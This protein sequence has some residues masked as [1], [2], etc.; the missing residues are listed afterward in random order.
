MRFTVLLL[1]SSLYTLSFGQKV[2]QY[3]NPFIGTSNY[4][5]THP[6]ANFPHGMASVTPF[7]VAHKKGE[8]NKFEKDS[9]WHSRPYVHENKFLTGFSHVNLSGVGCPDLGS[10]L[11]MPT[12][13]QLEFDSEKY[14]STYEN[15]VASPGYYS[16]ELIKYGVRT[17]MTSTLRTGLSKY[18]FPAG[19]SHIL[20]NLGLGL[21][22]ETGSYLRIV[23]P[24]EVEGFKNFGTFCYSDEDVRPV[25]FVMKLSKAP[26][27]FGAWKKMPP[28]Q[29]VEGE[30]IGYND[31]Y[32][33][34][35][36]YMFPLAGDDIG[37]YFTFTTS[38]DEQISVKVGIS[39]VS[40]EN[41]RENLES[42]QPK[43]EFENTHLANESKWDELL[44]RIVVESG[45]ENAKTIFYTA[46]YHNLIHPN[47]VN[48]VN[49]EYPKMSSHEIGKTETNRYTVFSIWDTYRNVHPLLSLV[50]PEIQSEMINTMLGMYEESGWLPK[51]ELIAMETD[52]MVGDP[53]TPVIT[54]TYLRGIRDF[55]IKKA[56]E[57]IKKA[58][59]TKESENRLRPGIDEYNK[60]GFVPVDTADIWGGS[61]ST[62]LEYY[63]ADWNIAQ[64]AKVLGY[65]EEARRY[66][67][68]SMGYKQLFDKSTGMLR[69]KFADGRWIPN[70]DPEAGKNFEAVVGYVE[71]NAWQYRFYVPHDIAGLTKLLGGKKKFYEQ[72]HLLF[73]TDNYDMANEP[74]I[75][76]PYLF[77]YIPGRERETQFQVNR[78]INKYYKNSPDGIP[79]NDDTGSLSAW[80]AFSMMGIYPVC[81]GDMDYAITSPYFDRVTI[82]LNDDYYPGREIVIESNKTSEKSIYID[83][84]S[85]NGKPIKEFFID[86]QQLTNGGIL[87]FELVE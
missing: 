61:V 39:Y 37:A 50:Y 87:K 48:D 18:T 85:F 63:I 15:E 25:Y 80:V 47:I 1:L 75:T 79:G 10:I 3:V 84:V 56:Y 28:Y 52:V 22:N 51:W 77:N 35:E 78:L 40:I 27:A 24:T 23:S 20:L 57:A 29:G 6:G 5:A 7:N 4:G 60:L 81:P 62:S 68:K 76:F 72:L 19:E 14:G 44:G 66:Q 8:E 49:G 58:S 55:D 43:F 11:L 86:H 13:G 70:F 12:T 71:G 42:E 82:Q 65:P 59:D 64:L 16:N 21:T 38:E 46:L 74:D 45:N 83:R 9:E 53:A 17:E 30:W 69:P 32:K 2:T 67:S 36:Q 26:K 31:T 73:E 54:D 33:P 41:A 34:Y